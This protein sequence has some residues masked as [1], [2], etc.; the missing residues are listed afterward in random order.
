MLLYSVILIAEILFSRTFLFPFL[1]NYLPKWGHLV[2]T[3]LTIL[4]MLPFLVALSFSTT[5]PDERMKLH[6]SASFYDVP[7]VAMRIV[8]YLIALVFI[9]YFT[10]LAY[11]S[12]TGWLVGAGC[13]I[14]IMVFAS[15]KLMQRYNRMEERFMNNLNSRENTRLGT[16]NNLVDDMH[17]AYIQ[18]GQCAPFVGDKIKDSRLRD[19]YGVSISSIQRGDDYMPLPSPMARI[20]PGDILGVIGSDDQLKK[21]NE[22]IESSEQACSA[23]SVTQHKV[24]LKS[25]RLTEHSPIAGIPLGQTN[26]QKDYYSMIV[27]V[28]RGEDE[29]IQP[30]ADMILRPGDAIWVVGD[31]AYF[32]KMK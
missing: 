1:E 28:Q 20:F 6:Q 30:G 8:R 32:D 12:L 26:I 17:Q 29:F 22:D 25:I 16:N 3:I 5:Q 31:P 27:K 11:S 24:E 2:A 23:V 19:D 7:L 13:F 15:T 18:I 21:L 10:T 4:A 9:T 14:L